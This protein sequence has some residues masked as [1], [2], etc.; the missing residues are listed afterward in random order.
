M[1][2]KHGIIAREIQGETVLLNME[3]GDYFSLNTVGN[4]IYK[5]ITN[6]MDIDGITTHITDSYDIDEKTAKED[7][8][9]LINDL[10]ANGV[11]ESD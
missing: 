6:N 9:S 2:I 5:C 4:E 8:L 7:V 1:K 10:I 11:I 3:T